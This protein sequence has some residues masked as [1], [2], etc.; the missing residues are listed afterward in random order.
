MEWDNNGLVWY[1]DGRPYHFR[2]AGNAPAIR[3]PVDPQ[4]LVMET[5]LAWWIEP[6]DQPANLGPSGEALH[7]IDWVRVWERV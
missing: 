7:F 4:Y 1:F 6:R 2:N 3:L 5:A